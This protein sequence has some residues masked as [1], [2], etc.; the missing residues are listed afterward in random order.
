MISIS[1]LSFGNNAFA[2][3][4]YYENCESG[5]CQK[6]FLIGK[7]RTDG[8]QFNVKVMLLNYRG[9]GPG[10]VDEHHKSGKVSCDVNKPTVA[11]TDSKPQLIDKSIF[12]K[13]M[14][15]KVAKLNDE[16]PKKYDENT[17]LWKKVC[18]ST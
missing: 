11:W 6:G 12:S 18:P 5:N 2:E 7:Q 4:L 16:P 8:N 1:S 17:S 3:D 9:K 15:K 10:E 13:K 14:N